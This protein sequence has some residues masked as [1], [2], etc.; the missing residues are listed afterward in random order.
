MSFRGRIYASVGEGTV[1]T[2]TT[3]KPRSRQASN[4]P[5]S[6][7][8]CDTPRFRSRSATRALVASFGQ[9]Q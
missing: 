8:M 9:E 7:R 4:P 3:G 6:G 1:V 5:A 2:G